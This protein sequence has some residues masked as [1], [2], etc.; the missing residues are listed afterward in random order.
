MIPVKL[1]FNG[2]YS[3][4]FP[5]E[6]H[7]DRLT[8]A[9]LFGIFGNT[10]SG[11]SSILD[12]ITYA[13]YRKADRLSGESLA[14]SMINLHANE[15]SIQFDCYAGERC[16]Q[17]YRF[18]VIEKRNSKR[19]EQMGT[20]KRNI[21]EQQNGEFIP[22]A[23]KGHLKVAEEIIGMSYDNFR[24]AIILPQGKFQEFVLKGATDRTKLLEEI[25]SLSKFDLKRGIDRL[26][27]EI[28]AQ[29]ENLRGQLQQLAEATPNII[30]ETEQQLAQLQHELQQKHE[31]LKAAYVLLEEAKAYSTAEAAYKQAETDYKKARATELQAT[32]LKQE[33]EQ[34]QLAMQ[35]FGE[36]SSRGAEARARQLEA[37][38][39]LAQ[40]Q[41]Q[42]KL[43]LAELT[44]TEKHYQQLKQQHDQ[45]PHWQEALQQKRTL[46][47]C[48]TLK[49]SVQVLEQ[50]QLTQQQ[51]L[52]STTAKQAATEKAYLQAKSFLESSAA[53][54][55]QESALLKAELAHTEVQKCAQ[56]VQQLN[57]KLED[58]IKQK[59]VLEQKV[60][61]VTEVLFNEQLLPAQAEQKLPS[62]VQKAREHQQE[63]QHALQELQLKKRFASASEKLVSGEPCLICGATEHP[64]PLEAHL[65]ETELQLAETVHQAAKAATEQLEKQ[66]PVITRSCLKHEQVLVVISECKTLV[67]TEEAKLADLQQSVSKLPALAAIAQQLQQIEQAKAKNKRAKVE[68]AHAEATRQQHQQETEALQQE[69]V[70]TA[71][72]LEALEEQLQELKAQL[73]S[74]ALKN[75]AAAT[76][77]PAEL[78]QQIA[79]LEQKLLVVPQQYQKALKSYNQLR[80]KA[81]GVRATLQSVQQSAAKAQE[82][83]TAAVSAYEAALAKSPFNE[84]EEVKALLAKKDN[85]QQMQAQH[86]TLQS[87]LTAAK[88]E[89]DRC[90]LALAKVQKPATDPATAG[91]RKN[92]LEQAVQQLTKEATLAHNQL[93]QYQKQLK[94]QQQLTK[95]V[96]QLNNRADMVKLLERLNK[97]K[98]FVNFAAKAYMG[99]VV[100]VANKR[101]MQLTHN[102][103]SL[104]ARPD[105]EIFVRDFLNGGQERSLKTLSGGQ[106]FQACLCLALSLSEVLQGHRK[107]S[108]SFFFLDEGFGSLDSQSLETVFATLK[109]LQNEQRI[110][111]IISH[112]EELKQK[113][114]AA[115]YVKRTAES[116]SVITAH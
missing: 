13:I 64:A 55:A 45:L 82:N 8:A 114:D 50:Q 59:Q 116:G 80:E 111:G 35:L 51:L 28:K 32:T 69:S 30:K 47:K 21:Y 54:I 101:F 37:N 5:A 75:L 99:Q 103:L 56:L 29:Q 23:D 19:P 88:T 2:I 7:F 81:A 76:P 113:V 60:A 68:L 61:Q 62:A 38:T 34:I 20:P 16:E 106:L 49:G 14:E 10:G 27:G 63:L 90:Q 66:Q 98:G 70:R 108:Q 112:V 11:K 77:Q 78:E 42:E 48:Q 31:A 12:A 83:F 104:E 96:E 87:S 72:K 3:Y 93:Q 41:Q 58:A 39:A 73:D 67:T 79:A 71:T 33:I 86:H 102:Q 105:N 9:G 24:I 44:Q 22:L 17:L 97:G 52:S 46:L 57:K 109:S 43:A 84:R 18:E 89:F 110:V 94:E 1:T 91:S 25:F 107:A 115:L 92:E 40:V 6:I 4:K 15:F 53:L 36:V 65:L 85:L 26:K 74:N 100:A 95:I